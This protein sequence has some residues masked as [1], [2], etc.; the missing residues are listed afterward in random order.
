NTRAQVSEHRSESPNSSRWV[1]RSSLMAQIRNLSNL[2]NALAAEF[3]WR[4]K[5]LHGLKTLVIANETTRS[6]DMC[7]RSAVPLLYAHWEGA[8]KKFAGHYLEF[9][10]RQKLR[11]D[12]LP[13]HFLAMA[14]RRL[15]HIA[16]ATSRIQPCLDVIEFFRSHMASRSDIDWKSG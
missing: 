2:Q 4:K 1:E 6:R 16:G 15:I 9:V 13:D 14:I 7:I 12:Q 10:G 3:A 8:I 5:E 11:N